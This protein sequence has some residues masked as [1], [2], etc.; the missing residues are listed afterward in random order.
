MLPIGLRRILSHAR[1]QLRRARILEPT[2]A[3]HPHAGPAT[4]VMAVGSSFDQARPDAMM[5]CRMGYCHAFEECGVPFLI[6]DV[7]D[8]VDILQDVP[9]PF[10]MYFGG[11]IHHLSNRAIKLLRRYPSIVWLYPWFRD[12]DTFFASHELDPAPWTLSE[13]VKRKIIELEPKFGFTATV[14]SGLGFFDEWKQRGITVV[15]LP[16]ACDTKLYS[17]NSS[18]VPA[19]SGVQLA[20]VGGY[21]TSKGR[22]IDRYL[23]QFEDRL[24]VYGYNEWPYTGYRGRLDA[25]LEPS[26]Y[27]Q[28]MIAPAVNEPTVQLLKGQINERVFK[29]LGSYGCPVVDAVPAYRELYTENELLVS[30]GPEDFREIVEMLLSDVDMNERYR[31]RGHAATL[32]R[33]TYRHRAETIL[34]ELHMSSLA[35]PQ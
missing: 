19:F 2:G 12:S 18:D 34:R 30:D 35:R 17:K 33:H 6:A 20:F 32:D 21:W 4:F 5:T 26:L 9:N 1:S 7:R 13:T 8:L 31:Q 29:V 16:L 25:T 23:R 15:S 11:D 10:C 27:R 3:I 14:P 22:Q 28:A 24:V